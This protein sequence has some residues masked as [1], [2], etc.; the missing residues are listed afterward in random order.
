MIRAVTGGQGNPS[1]ED[2]NALR[3]LLSGLLKESPAH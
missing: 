3:A 1:L 2:V